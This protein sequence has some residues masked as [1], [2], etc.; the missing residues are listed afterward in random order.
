MNIVT[1]KSRR[2]DT[3]PR[4]SYTVQVLTVGFNL[5][6]TSDIH[7]LRS[8]ANIGTT[9]VT[10]IKY[11]PCGTWGECIDIPTRRLKSTVNQVPSLRDFAVPAFGEI[12]NIQPLIRI[13]NFFF[14]SSKILIRSSKFLYPYAKNPVFLQNGF[15]QFKRI[16]I[17]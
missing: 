8:P 16:I 11:R 13:S 17:Q 1:A 4:T 12:R 6:K 7:T 14:H 5:R 9:H 3:L 2:D 10:G 15:H